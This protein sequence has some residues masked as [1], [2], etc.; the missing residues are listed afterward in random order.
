[1][2]EGTRLYLKCSFFVIMDAVMIWK[3]KIVMKDIVEMAGVGKTIVSCYFNEDYVKDFEEID[4]GFDI[5]AAHSFLDEKGRRILIGWMWLSDVDYTI[6]TV[7][8]TIFELHI[9][10]IQDQFSLKLRSD[11]TLENE[12]SLLMKVGYGRKQRHLKVDHLDYIVIFSEWSSLECDQEVELYYLDS[13]KIMC[14][15]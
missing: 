12:N 6:P 10:K 13:F 1:M 7:E 11:F 5:Y 3:K 9:S 15:K 2:V 14:E 4:N 8:N